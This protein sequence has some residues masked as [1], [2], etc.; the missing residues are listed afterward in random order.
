[1]ESNSI[2]VH[3]H[4]ALLKNRAERNNTKRSQQKGT[5]DNTHGTFRYNN[6]NGF[7]FEPT[8]GNNVKNNHYHSNIKFNNQ[9]TQFSMRWAPWEDW[10]HWMP[11]RDAT[12][13]LNIKYINLPVVH[14]THQKRRKRGRNPPPTP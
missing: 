2:M 3:I 9:K 10:G 13:P 1:M 11:V 4:I 8:R 14:S 7:T 12:F 5:L 6:T